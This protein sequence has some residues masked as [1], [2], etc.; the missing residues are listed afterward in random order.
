LTE[1][2]TW[3]AIPNIHSYKKTSR[4]QSKFE[5]GYALTKKQYGT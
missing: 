3:L 1:K 2:A 5:N 4:T